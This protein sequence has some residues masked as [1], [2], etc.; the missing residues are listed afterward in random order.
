MSTTFNVPDLDWVCRFSE[1]LLIACVEEAFVTM[2]PLA[3][4]KAFVDM[5]GTDIVVHD[6]PVTNEFLAWAASFGL[7]VICPFCPKD[8]LCQA[9][10]T[11][12]TQADPGTD[13]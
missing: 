13:A 8:A 3:R 1:T 5:Q 2:E 10:Q 6:G 4:S 9:C 11:E 7:R 12:R